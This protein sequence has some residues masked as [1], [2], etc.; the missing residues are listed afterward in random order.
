M[1]NYPFS[2]IGGM[3]G[4]IAGA[5]FYPYFAPAKVQQK[6]V[7]GKLKD[8]ALVLAEHILGGAVV[9]AGLGLGFDYLNSK[10]DDVRLVT[11]GTPGSTR[12][13]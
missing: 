11:P 4:A 1:A 3:H 5:M 12:I 9:G 2:L 10:Q 7:N 13:Y 8:K 6:L